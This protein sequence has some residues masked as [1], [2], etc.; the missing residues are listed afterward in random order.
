MTIKTVYAVL[1]GMAVAIL[2]LAAL[3]GLAIVN[4]PPSDLEKI[5]ANQ[6][7]REYVAEVMT[8]GCTIAGMN[9]PGFGPQLNASRGMVCF[10]VLAPNIGNI[11]DGKGECKV[12]DKRCLFTAGYV[13]TKMRALQEMPEGSEGL[14]KLQE[15]VDTMFEKLNSTKEKQ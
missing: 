5:V 9:D 7:M 15:D 14:K 1:L 10:Q 8:S 12:D 4:R 13:L 3:V 11:M 6:Q 2:G